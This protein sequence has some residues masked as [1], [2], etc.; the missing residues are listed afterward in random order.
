[1]QGGGAANHGLTN[2]CAATL[3][4]PCVPRAGLGKPWSASN[5]NKLL[6]HGSQRRIQKTSRNMAARKGP[7]LYRNRNDG[8][9]SISAALHCTGME[10]VE[11]V[12]PG[13]VC[14]SQAPHHPSHTVV[15]GCY[16][17]AC[18]CKATTSD[19]GYSCSTDS[20]MLSPA[21]QTVVSKSLFSAVYDCPCSGGNEGS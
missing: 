17:P 15:N 9:M 12:P 4:L 21:G 5:A 18:A 11:G 3:R 14:R 10:C 20:S 16:D 13:E 7:R 1:M 2:T 6:H 19:V 8:A